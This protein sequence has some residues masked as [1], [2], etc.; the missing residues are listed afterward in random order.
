VQKEEVAKKKCYFD[1]CL[2]IP[3]WRSVV[4]YSPIIW[5]ALSHLILQ[6]VTDVDKLIFI[7]FIAL[8]GLF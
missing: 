4:L 7:K 6:F 3:K 2:L 8:M 5:N 1:R